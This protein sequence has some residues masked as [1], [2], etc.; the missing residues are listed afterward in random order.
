MSEHEQLVER[1]VRPSVIRDLLP[2]RRLRVIPGR[3]SDAEEVAK[4]LVLSGTDPDR[5]FCSALIM[6]AEAGETYVL[7]NQW[8]RSTEVTLAKLAEAFPEAK[9]TFRRAQ[10]EDE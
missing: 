6:D 9:V 8:G 7:N 1:G 4:A 3:V 10:V 2:D 5:Y